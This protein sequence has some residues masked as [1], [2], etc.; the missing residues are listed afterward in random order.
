MAEL[1]I[2]G[3]AEIAKLDLGLGDVLVVRIRERIVSAEAAH[4]IKQSVEEIV[5]PGARVMVIDRDIDLSVLTKAE[6]EAR[7]GAAPCSSR[8]LICGR[9]ARGR[10]LPISRSIS[11]SA[12]RSRASVSPG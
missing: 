5:P 4:R 10:G 6:I 9:R 11:A 7:I 2:K 8:P 3:V 1:E 12:G